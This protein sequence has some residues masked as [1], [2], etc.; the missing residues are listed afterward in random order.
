MTACVSMEYRFFEPLTTGDVAASLLADAIELEVL[1]AVTEIVASLINEELDWFVPYG[2]DH[3]AGVE[4]E[5][6]D[7]DDTIKHESRMPTVPRGN[8]PE[9]AAEKNFAFV[10]SLL[11][12]AEERVGLIRTYQRGTKLYSAHVDRDA[13]ELES[14][15]RKAPAHELGA[16]PRDRASAGRMNAQ[17]VPMFYGALDA[18]TTCAEVA[19]HSP[20]DEASSS[21]SSITR[22]YTC[23]VM[24]PYPALF[25][26]GGPKRD[27]L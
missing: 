10:R 17:V 22:S 4:F 8:H 25:H 27:C 5:W 1:D 19:A 16:A 2:M 15:A 3:E 21:G 14:R 6:N 18:A 9:S 23:S 26:L 11:V 13:R 24:S 20:Y 12:L 7:F